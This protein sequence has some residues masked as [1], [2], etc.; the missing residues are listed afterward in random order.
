MRG[1]GR[2]ARMGTMRGRLTVTT[3]VVVLVAG[4]VAI[5]HAGEADAGP[6]FPD[7]VR[8]AA[9]TLRQH[10]QANPERY[11]AAPPVTGAA[12][13]NPTMF[14]NDPAGDAPFGEGDIVRAGF[15]RD[16]NQFVF[17]MEV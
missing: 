4:S 7:R 15:G 9:A 6:S 5:A 17:S 16:T 3:L 1:R 8:S 11:T 2:R 12:A 13:V 14:I 10:A